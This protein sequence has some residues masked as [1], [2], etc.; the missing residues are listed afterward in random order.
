MLSDFNKIFGILRH[1]EDPQFTRVLTDLVFRGHC[2]NF[3]RVIT[4][5]GLLHTSQK[6]MSEVRIFLVELQAVVESI[7]L[8][9]TPLVCR[10]VTVYDGFVFDPSNGADLV[11]SRLGVT[12]KNRVLAPLDVG[13]DFHS[14]FEGTGS[15][16][17]QG[18][19]Q[20]K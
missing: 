3:T 19:E 17:G 12:G 7:E 13:R 18:G 5:T 14:N 2:L 1:P 9:L 11:E 6:K 8:T 20:R 10:G 16:Q 15:G 4:L